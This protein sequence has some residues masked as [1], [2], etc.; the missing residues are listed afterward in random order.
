MSSS[1]LDT[2]LTRLITQAKQQ[3]DEIMEHPRSAQDD[4]DAAAVVLATVQKIVNT[5]TWSEGFQD[6]MKACRE[7]YREKTS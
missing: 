7:V 2:E 4:G 1:T 6:G 3:L 5:I